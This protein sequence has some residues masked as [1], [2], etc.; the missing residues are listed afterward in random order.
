MSAALE[1]AEYQTLFEQSRDAI[2]I[3][4]RDGR[5]VDVN[6]A[7]LRLFGYSRPELLRLNAHELYADCVARLLFQQQIEE[8]GSVIEYEV[9]LR[10]RDSVAICCL[11]TAT[12]RR[13]PNGEI[14]GY[15]GIIRDITHRRRLEEQLR[16]THK[17]DALGQLA[18]GVAHDFNNLLTGIT[19]YTQLALGKADGDTPASVDL[20]RVLEYATRAAGLTRQLLAFSRQQPLETK[21]FNL[22]TLVESTSKMLKRLIGEDIET[23]VNTAPDLANVRA[24]EGEIEQIVLNLAINARDAMP[25]GGRLTIE[26]C[27]A[28]LDEG[29]CASET[30][31]KAGAYVMVAVTDTGTG[32][33]ERTRKQVFE[34]FFTTKELGKGTG[35][36][37]ATAYGIVKQHGGHIA[38]CSEP[39]KGAAFRVYLP[40]VDAELDGIDVPEDAADAGTGTETILL[41]EDEEAVREVAA[42]GLED[43]GYRVL[44]AAHPDEAETLFRIHAGEIDLLITDVV[45]PGMD[46]TELYQRL[47]DDDPSM[48]V[49]YISGYPAS[50]ITRMRALDPDAH[51]LAKPFNP[52]QLARMV[53]TVLDD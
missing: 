31:L 7:M 47:R 16:Q 6:D 53:R 44:V 41:V 50:G 46:G 33:D 52:A 9:T 8:N 4:D 1:N 24:D 29:Y 43:H 11:E 13:A 35:L 15:R 37:L 22:N 18:G 42:M 19:G 26:T 48:D 32:M 28:I 40:R 20:R 30:D 51:F 23:E 14:V 12:L 38:V 10:T 49:L 3:T 17:M 27:N 2:Y 45:M 25:D 36:G 39:G 21:V 34:P 5:F